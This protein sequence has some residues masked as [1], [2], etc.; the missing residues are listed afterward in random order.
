MNT[1]IKKM[2]KKKEIRDEDSPLQAAVSMFQTP[3]ASSQ[4]NN[5]YYCFFNTKELYTGVHQ[6][7]FKQK[8]NIAAAKF[9]RP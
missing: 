4:L 1:L 5:T 8:F 6:A 2:Q 3:G 7:K 9:K